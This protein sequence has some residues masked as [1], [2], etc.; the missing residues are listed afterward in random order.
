MLNSMPMLAALRP[1]L[2]GPTSCACML[3]LR[4]DIICVRHQIGRRCAEVA[5]VTPRLVML[6]VIIHIFERHDHLIPNQGV[7][8]SS[9]AG[10]AKKINMLTI[11]RHLREIYGVPL[12]YQVLRCACD[13]QPRSSKIPVASYGA[14]VELSVRWRLRLKVPSPFP[15][16]IRIAKGVRGV[17]GSTESLIASAGLAHARSGG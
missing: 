12:G 5:R 13:A 11:I 1:R 6:G 17:S 16:Q 15:D 4:Y 7:A 8:G 3:R 9:P 10:V 2:C 14:T